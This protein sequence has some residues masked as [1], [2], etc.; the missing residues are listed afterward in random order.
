MA[1]S[2]PTEIVARTDG[3]VVVT[4]KNLEGRVPEAGALLGYRITQIAWDDQKQRPMVRKRRA[5]NETP[6]ATATRLA[7]G[8]TRQS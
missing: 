3:T 6:P 8:T 1:R 5:C 2:F 7:G 4:N